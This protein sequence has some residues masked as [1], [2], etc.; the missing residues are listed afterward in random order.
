MKPLRNATKLLAALAVSAAALPAVAAAQ[1]AAAP[2]VKSVNTNGSGRVERVLVRTSVKAAGRYAVT[3][4]VTSH[5]PANLHV[6]LTIG[7]VARTTKTARLTHRS[8]V[9]QQVQLTGRAFT[10]RA[11]AHRAKPTI[12]VSWRRMHSKPRT[13]PGKGQSVPPVVAPVAPALVAPIPAVVT[14]PAPAAPQTAAQGPLGDPGNWNLSFDDEFNA[15]SLDTSV[16]NTGWLSSGLTGPMNTEEEQCY[17]P[18]QAVEGSG[19]LDLNMAATPQ[20]G[21]V[22]AGGPGTV[23]EPYVSAMVNTRQKFSYTYGYLETRVWLP[24]PVT[25]GVDWPGVW[26][27][28][29]PAPQNGE[30]DVVEG[31]GGRACWHF[32]DSTGAGYGNCAVGYSGGWHTFGAD[33]EPGSVTWYYDGTAVGV[34]TTNITTQP[35]YLIADLAADTQWGGPVSAPATMKIDYIR[36]FQH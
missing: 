27:V 10:V 18:S 13:A 26:E 32:H 8:I 22:L 17:S 15:T 33:W 1:S 14:A 7:G 30:I 11:S 28:G 23:D 34:E 16:W 31:L 24:G 4:K 9:R 6:R 3:V 25:Q 19:E 29:S 2:S 5:T 20:T 35:M 21:C 36:V 12:I